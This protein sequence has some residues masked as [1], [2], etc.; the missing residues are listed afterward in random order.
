M[1]AYLV[2][3]V[4]RRVSMLGV[5]RVRIYAN[6]KHFRSIVCFHVRVGA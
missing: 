6:G 4:G 1:Y 3:I 2:V 5:G